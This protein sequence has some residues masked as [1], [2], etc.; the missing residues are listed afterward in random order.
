MSGRDVIKRAVE[1]TLATGQLEGE[2]P[3]SLLITAQ[4]EEGKT[5]LVAQYASLPSVTYLADATA[6]GIVEKYQKDLQSGSVSHLI[7]PELIRPLERS[8]ETAAGFV[9]F[10]GELIEEGIKEMQTFATSFKLPA[11]IKAGVIACIARGHLNHRLRHWNE[12]GFLSRFLVMSYSYGD[13]TAEEI[14]KAITLGTPSITST[15]KLPAKGSVCLPESIGDQL[16]AIAQTLARRLFAP[17]HGFRMQKHLGRLAKASALVDGRAVVSGS[18]LL[19]VIE[20]AKYVN[21]DYKAI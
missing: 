21:L 2:Q 1:L 18:D 12:T 19:A 8:K 20:I 4:V 6:Y 11:P 16:A 3:G 7:F 9:A 10:L 5:H 13:A 15:F 14:R 17:L